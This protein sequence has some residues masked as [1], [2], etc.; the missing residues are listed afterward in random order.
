MNLH[1]LSPKMM[2]K[3]KNRRIGELTSKTQ[4]TSLIFLCMDLKPL[5]FKEVRKT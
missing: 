3:Q 4:S 2:P 5:C 1:E